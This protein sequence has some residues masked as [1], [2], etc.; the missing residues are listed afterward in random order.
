M[1]WFTDDKTE[2]QAI[3]FF[4]GLMQLVNGGTGI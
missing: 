1:N 3:H 2:A 4:L